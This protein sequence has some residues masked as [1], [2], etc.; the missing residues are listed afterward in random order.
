VDLGLEAWVPAGPGHAEDED[1]APSE[2]HLQPSPTPMP[3]GA[4]SSDLD[5]SELTEEPGAGAVPQDGRVAR[6]AAPPRS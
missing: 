3:G 5:V 4:A 1:E 2:Q 6:R